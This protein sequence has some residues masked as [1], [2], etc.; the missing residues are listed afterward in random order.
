MTHG[1]GAGAAGAASA[2]MRAVEG[3]VSVVQL[4]GGLVQLDASAS[5][6]IFTCQAVCTRVAVSGP[7][8][9]GSRRRSSSNTVTSRCQASR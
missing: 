1:P 8:S 9:A 4:G 5:C 3:A 6:R 2:V 7:F